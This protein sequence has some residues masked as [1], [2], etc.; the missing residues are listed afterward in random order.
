[1]PVGIMVV[2]IIVGVRLGW[3]GHHVA[4]RQLGIVG[5]LSLLGPGVGVIVAD[6]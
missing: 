2:G 6:G 1:M 5:T 3:G 4:K